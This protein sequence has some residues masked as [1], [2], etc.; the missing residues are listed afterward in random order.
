MPR[1]QGTDFVAMQ[2]AKKK[3]TRVGIS[4]PEPQLFTRLTSPLLPNNFVL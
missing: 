4:N 2:K 1:A 3:I